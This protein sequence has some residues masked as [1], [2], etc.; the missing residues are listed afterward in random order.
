MLRS[1]Q[2]FWP[3]TGRPRGMQPYSGN[4]LS[5]RRQAAEAIQ[6]LLLNKQINYLLCRVVVYSDF[7]PPELMWLLLNATFDRRK[8]AELQLRE[9]LSGPGS[10]RLERMRL[11][12]GHLGL[13]V[14]A[15][16]QGLVAHCD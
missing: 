13:E 8:D 9:Q 14:R 5:W 11:F 16:A 7:A 2:H 1:P 15:G 4:W 6:P 12:R 10:R 3:D